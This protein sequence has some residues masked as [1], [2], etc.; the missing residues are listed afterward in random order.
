MGAD[1]YP[2]SMDARAAWHPIFAAQIQPLAAKYG[3]TAG[4][5]TQIVEDSIWMV[6]TVQLRHEFNSHSQQLTA[7]F[8]AI[9]GNDDSLEPPAALNFTDLNTAPPPQPPPGIEKRTREYARQIKGDL[10][11]SVA[12]GEL[13]GIAAS[14]QTPAN[15]ALLTA[16]FTVRT[17][18]NFELEVTFRKHGMTA[19]KLQFRYKGGNWQ[20]AGFLV[21]SPG[22]IA[23]AP[24]EPFTAE[25]VELR[26]ILIEQNE[27]V[28]SYSDP[29]PAFIAP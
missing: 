23:I 20:S 6:Y 21:T 4:Q 14:E 16:E 25:Q 12:D 24:S 22:T 27:E 7:F 9:A 13:L 2:A 15:P 8:N 26:A 18:A 19:V 10:D 1:F 5:V 28:G 3:I 17:L 29:K 11:Y